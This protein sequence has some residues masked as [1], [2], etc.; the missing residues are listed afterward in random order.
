MKRIHLDDLK[1]VGIS[2]NKDIKKKVFLENGLI[3]KLT[4]FAMATFKPGQKVE[5]HKHETM[6]EIFYI[7]SGR[8]EFVIQGEKLLVQE[9]DCVVVEPGEEHS[10]ENPNKEDVTWL[11]FGV[12]TD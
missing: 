2:H 9:G 3:P 12:A 4:T 1:E 8:A 10:Q 5:T 11:Y 6:F 7:Q